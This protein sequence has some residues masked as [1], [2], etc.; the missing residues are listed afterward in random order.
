[1]VEGLRS[2]TIFALAGQKSNHAK[3][4][5]YCIS[6]LAPN[7]IPG[8]KSNCPAWV[9][10][11]QWSDFLSSDG[12]DYVVQ[13]QLVGTLERGAKE[14]HCELSR[15]SKKW[16]PHRVFLS[17]REGGKEGRRE[18]GNE[19]GKSKSKYI[20]RSS[21]WLHESNQKVENWVSSWRCSRHPV[22][23]YR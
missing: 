5:P 13:T 12:Q 14:N 8:K 10:C 1:M 11:P 19:G 6:T 23:P 3:R 22:I 7:P 17:R 21:S 4:I 20:W 18:E 15:R 16:L 2:T 9:G